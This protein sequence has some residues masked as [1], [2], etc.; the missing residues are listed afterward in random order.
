MPQF[1]AASIVEPLE[2]TFAYKVG[3]TAVPGPSGVIAEP[4]DK[5]VGK[6][7]RGLKDLMGGALKQMGIEDGADLTDP[8]QMMRALDDL[9]PDEYVKVEAQMAQM[10]AELCSGSPSKAQIL[11]L[12]LRRRRLFYAWLQQEALSPEAVPGGGNAQVTVL[13]SRA[14]G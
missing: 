3:D 13:P 12:P 8:V 2:Y 4:S 14:A 5:Q 6:F 9:E 10:H 7:L 11:A 1:D